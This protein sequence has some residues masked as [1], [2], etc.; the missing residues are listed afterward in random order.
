PRSADA[1]GRW[2]LVVAD[3]QPSTLQAFCPQDLGYL[4]DGG[5]DSCPRG[6]SLLG[7]SNGPSRDRARLGF[8]FRTLHLLAPLSSLFPRMAKFGL[9]CFQRLGRG[10]SLGGR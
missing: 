2:N 3:R 9:E 1:W 8:P 5:K 7:A 6:G 4:L 10:T